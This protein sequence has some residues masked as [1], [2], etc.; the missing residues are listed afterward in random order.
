MSINIVTYN[1]FGTLDKGKYLKK[2]PHILYK[3][4]LKMENLI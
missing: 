1:V 3:R 4:Y 2:E